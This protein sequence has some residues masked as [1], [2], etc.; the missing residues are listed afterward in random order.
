MVSIRRW[1]L[2]ALAL[3]TIAVGCAGRDAP[4]VPA[5]AAS[6]AAPAPAAE[7]PTAPPQ[8]LDPGMRTALTIQTGIVEET[9][10][11]TISERLPNP[12]SAEAMAAPKA[13]AANDASAVATVPDDKKIA[14]LFTGHDIGELDPCG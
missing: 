2:S 14:L 11:L 12:P 5:L 3:A 8:L 10:A 9:A 13:E 4:P 1:R 7:E 6:A